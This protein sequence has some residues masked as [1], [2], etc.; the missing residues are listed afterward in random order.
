VFFFFFRVRVL[1]RIIITPE[2]AVIN[3]ETIA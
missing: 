1:K 2:V 3:E